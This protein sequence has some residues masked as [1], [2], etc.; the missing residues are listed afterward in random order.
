MPVVS[1][2]TVCLQNE[3]PWSNLTSTAADPYYYLQDMEV[4]GAS[5]GGGGGEWR[6]CLELDLKIQEK[7]SHLVLKLISFLSFL[8]F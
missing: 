1:L 5:G 4:K 6:H 7:E 8:G 2:I 3:Q